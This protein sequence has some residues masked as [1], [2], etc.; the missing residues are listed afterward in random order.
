MNATINTAGACTP[1]PATATMKPSVAARLY[2]GAV[3]A[4]AMTR[5]EIVPDRVALRGP[6]GREASVS[7]AGCCVP[8]TA[9][10]SISS[11]LQDVDDFVPRPRDATVN[12]P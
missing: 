12:A 6:Y 10:L 2:A 9:A 5:F 7:S 3:D 11:P 1:T 4:T 8:V